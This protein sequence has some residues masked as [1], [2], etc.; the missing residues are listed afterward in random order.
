MRR[1]RG[2]T[3]LEIMVALA[4]F[5]IAVVSL[6]RVVGGGAQHVDELARRQFAGMLAHN[7]LVLAHLEGR[8]RGDSGKAVQGPFE[9]YWELSVE[10]TDTEAIAR[11]EMDVYDDRDEPPLASLSAFAE[12][13]K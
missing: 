3:L 13:G 1:A 12:T 8:L 7:Q 10:E 2:F 9:Y 5:A 4:I 6:A 11:L